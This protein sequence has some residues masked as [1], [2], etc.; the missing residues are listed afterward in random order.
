MTDDDLLAQAIVFILAG[1]TTSST[2]LS[3]LLYELAL[4]PEIQERLQAEVDEI[5]QKNND[6]VTYA[7]ITHM[8]YLDM[9][10]S[11]INYWNFNIFMVLIVR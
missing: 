9:V 7:D 6:K 8:K 10:V 11:G 2:L 3:F 1:F 4:N 5:L